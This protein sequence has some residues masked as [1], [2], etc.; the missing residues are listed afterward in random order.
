MVLKTS[1]LPDDCVARRFIMLTYYRVRST[2]KAPRALTSNK[3]LAF[4]TI[5]YN[6]R[7]VESRKFEYSMPASSTPL[8]QHSGKFYMPGKLFC[9]A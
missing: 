3:I 5:L 8:L 7:N 4:K 9:R 6:Y 2:Y 1:L